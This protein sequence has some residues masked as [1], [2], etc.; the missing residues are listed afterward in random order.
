MSNFIIIVPKLKFKHKLSFDNYLKK[1][2]ANTKS[3]VN[4]KQ[5]NLFL[6]LPDFA[7]Y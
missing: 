7:L 3:I 2:R 6:K 1:I 4:E 5:G